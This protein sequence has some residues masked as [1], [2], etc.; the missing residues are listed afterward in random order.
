MRSAY[1]KDVDR[2]ISDLSF[3]LGTVLGTPFQRKVWR[4]HLIST[5]KSLGD[6]R[7]CASSDR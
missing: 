1:G 3:H 7:C 2:K 4:E 6:K 5:T